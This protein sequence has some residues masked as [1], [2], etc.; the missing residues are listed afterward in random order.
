MGLVTQNHIYIYIYINRQTYIGPIYKRILT[1]PI[2]HRKG[3]MPYAREDQSQI[4]NVSRYIYISMRH[5]IKFTSTHII[6][7]NQAPKI[8]LRDP[9]VLGC[10]DSSVA[11]ITLRV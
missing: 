1:E 6:V 7:R 2:I 9:K 11:R 3:H 4:Y 8:L 5:I 10:G